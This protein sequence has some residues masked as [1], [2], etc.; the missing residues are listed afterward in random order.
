[1]LRLM[2]TLLKGARARAEERVTDAYAIE[3]IEQKIR[4]AQA[5]FRSAKTTLATLMQRQRVEVRAMDDLDTRIA[6]LMERAGQALNAGRDDLAKEAAAAIADLENEK[7]VR[8]QTLDRLEAKITRLRHSLDKAN[9]RIIDLKQGAIGARAVERERR[10]QA[11]LNGRIAQTPHIAEAEELIAR[12]MGQ[13]DPFEQAEILSEIDAALDHSGVADRMGD[14]GFG[15][16][17]RTRAED[18]LA[19]LKTSS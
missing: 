2:D 13:D 19:R 4:E 14:A 12:V 5:S 16:P 8:Q 17:S 9:R 6:D 1:M 7:A 11:G 18:V 3:L 10:A 15:A